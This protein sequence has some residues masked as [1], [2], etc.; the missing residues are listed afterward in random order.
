MNIIEIDGSFGEGGGQILRSS[1]SLSLVTGKPFLIK[2][3]RAGRKKPGLLRQHLTAVQ[4]GAEIGGAEVDGDFI[5]SQRLYFAPKT[6]KPGKYHFAIGTAGSCTLVLQA[7]LPALLTAESA[8]ELTLEG[9]THNPFAPPF[10]F[11]TKAFLPVI[12]GM[13]PGI[14][15]VLERPGFYPA[16]GGRLKIG[17]KP[18][19]KL[20][21]FIFLERGQIKN[22]Q[23]VASV[24]R[25]PTKIAERELK[26][27][28][29]RLSWSKDCLQV[30]NIVN[31]KGPGNIVSL[32]IEC[33][34][35]T[36]VFT[37]F[38]QKGIPAEIVAE[39]AVKEAEEY[40]DSD[41]PVGKY[42]ADQ[43]LIPAALAGGG[44]FRTILP[45]HH[46]ITNIEI[47]KKFLPVEITTTQLHDKTWEIEIKSHRDDRKSIPD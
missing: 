14:S 46:T 41:A 43:L 22:Y 12:N 2:N 40:L 13:G 6:I 1:L 28:G 47:I 24:A 25:L 39:N 20:D 18:V 42:L 5:G 30:K 35:I 15:A 31:S 19:K 7:A 37:A 17:I 45:T 16:G 23:A 32:E 26:V 9:G 38:G 21:T 4:A 27:V 29:D 44:K 11:L 10:D 3:I 36:E 8:A 34:N 33:E